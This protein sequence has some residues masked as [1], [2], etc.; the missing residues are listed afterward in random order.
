[1]TSLTSQGVNMGESLAIS[2]VQ[3]IPVAGT[4]FMCTVESPIHQSIKDKIVA[5]TET[6]TVHIF[7]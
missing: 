7:R 1:M 4:R 5:S 2:E 3:L 6:D